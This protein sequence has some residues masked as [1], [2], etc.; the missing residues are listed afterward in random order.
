MSIVSNKANKKNQIYL[1]GIIILFVL[2][3]FIKSNL[4]INLIK[5]DEFIEADR[6]NDLKS[7]KTS[8]FWGPN[9]VSY[10]HINNNWTD[11]RNNLP[12]V[13]G[14][15]GSWDNPFYIEN[16]TID[17]SDSPTGSG[18]LI[19]NSIVYFRIEN[20][21]IYNS[22]YGEEYAGIQLRNTYNSKIIDNI[23]NDNNYR[24]IALS[25]CYNNTIL[26]NIANDN[27]FNGIFL[28]SCYNN[29]I[30]NN[31]ANYN[32]EHSGIFL[33]GCNNNTISGNNANSNVHNGI[34]LQFS[35]YNNVSGNTANYNQHAGIVLGNS[36]YNNIIGNVLINNELGIEEIDLCIG[37]IIR[38]NIIHDRED[39]GDDDDDGNDT[40]ENETLFVILIIFIIISLICGGFS[41]IIG[42]K[43]EN[44]DDEPKLDS[45]ELE[46]EKVIEEEYILCDLC[47][48]KIKKGSEKCSYCGSLLLGISDD[49]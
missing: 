15:D 7:R 4:S 30:S 9:E 14:G 46:K 11:A 16:V 22:D 21:T 2:L 6:A 5:T 31:Y 12:W 47:G 36:N 41:I 26:G 48:E 40:I 20:C 44:L 10:I 43:S 45:S 33:W 18:I 35:N 13:Q 29:N 8:G 24:G 34:F 23:V 32:K 28:G 25:N 42:R 19:E 37:N 39:N 1:F 3:A 49:D 27:F 17:A 38:N